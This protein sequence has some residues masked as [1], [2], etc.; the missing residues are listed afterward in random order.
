VY[1]LEHGERD[2]ETEVFVREP[3]APLHL[4]ARSFEVGNR[5]E[6]PSLRPPPPS[7]RDVRRD[8][9][10][11]GV[12]VGCVLLG[13][14]IGCI[15]VFGGSSHSQAAAPA[16]E[17]AAPRPVV[18][19]VASTPQP[20]ETARVAIR[21]D[22]EPAGAAAVLVDDGQPRVLGTTPLNAQVDP[23]KQYDVILTLDGHHTHV[24]H[25]DPAHD[26]HVFVM[27]APD[28]QP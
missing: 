15:I 24:E 14:L 5:F 26:Q 16:L 28:A 1:W 9:V 20:I 25:L 8:L 2:S 23:H 4:S 10:G 19:P 13:I 17:P 6:V 18:R 22:S 11:I 7:R 21:L 12:G 27:L 3:L